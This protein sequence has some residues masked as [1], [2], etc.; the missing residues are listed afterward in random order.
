MNDAVFRREKDWIK[1]GNTYNS[2]LY[3]DGDGKW[4]KDWK[5]WNGWG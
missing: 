1:T 4:N 3:D 5:I 2:A